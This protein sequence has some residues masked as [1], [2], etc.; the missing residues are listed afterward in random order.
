MGPSAMGRGSTDPCQLRCRIM[1]Q[2]S[3]KS[4]FSLYDKPS[5]WHSFR[6][7]GPPVARPIFPLGDPG[8]R[9]TWT[10]VRR[11]EDAPGHSRRGIDY[12]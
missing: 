4:Q 9:S 6:P 11:A 5:I 12:I 10:A 1:F 7:L 3:Y 2:F 8:F